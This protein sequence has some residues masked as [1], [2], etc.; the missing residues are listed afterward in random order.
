MRLGLSYT[1]RSRIG[2]GRMGVKLHQALTRAG[3]DV[4]ENLLVPPDAHGDERS[5]LAFLEEA[6][7]WRAGVAAET[8]WCAV[9]A[10]VPGKYDGQGCHIF[11]MWETTTIPESFRENLHWFDSVLVPSEQNRDIF[12]KWHGNVHVVPLGID[13]QEWPFVAR[14]EPE[15]EFR[16]LCAGSGVRKGPDLAVQA[17]H[18]VFPD[19]APMEPVPRLVLK[20]PRGESHH[21]PFVT[22]VA[23]YLD[24]DT[25]RA[26]YADCHVYVGPSR[27]EGFGLQPLQAMS[28]GM[29]TILTDAHGHAGFAHLG[30]PIR[31]EE[32]K[33][34]AEFMWGDGVDW[35]E[36]DLDELCEAMW[37]TYA[38][39]GHHRDRAALHA[40]IVQ[41]DWTWDHTA[42]RVIDV[43]PDLERPDPLS[44]TWIKSERRLFHVRV[45]KQYKVHAA[46][47][48]YEFYPGKD[49][50]ESADV[51]RVLFKA[52][53]LD[54]ACLGD[55]NHGLSEGQAREIGAYSA[56]HERCSSCGQ[57]LP[58]VSD[59]ILTPDTEIGVPV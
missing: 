45:T 15:T 47:Y 36:P 46:G 42:R 29:P 25:E 32:S 19:P 12:S 3:V 53:L 13:P 16:F 58:G 24:D 48:L 49:Y 55:E 18:K 1:H 31:A 5:Q 11:T 37:D 39:W 52:D 20:S 40:D 41:R 23:G 6:K 17:F 38:R 30:I 9:P 2:Y 4:C 26:L 7:D 34:T 14:R 56:K 54:P 43:L 8:L 35:W 28:Q 33:T 21:S 27:G 51:K 22:V 50:W 57:R 10:H 44:R 59:E